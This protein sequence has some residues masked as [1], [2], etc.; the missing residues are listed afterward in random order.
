MS[1]VTPVLFGSFCCTVETKWNLYF[2]Y[3]V[4][5]L[6]TYLLNI[7]TYLTYIL[8]YSMQQSLS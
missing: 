5:D 6:L 4:P 1:E 7:H 8:T 2:M 3:P